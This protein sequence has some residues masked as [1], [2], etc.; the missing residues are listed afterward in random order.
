M[1]VRPR[2][3]NTR[4]TISG[5]NWHLLEDLAATRRLRTAARTASAQMTAATILQRSTTI[6]GATA[7]RNAVARSRAPPPC[8]DAPAHVSDSRKDDAGD[9]LYPEAAQTHPRAGAASMA[10]FSRAVSR[11]AFLP[12]ATEPRAHRVQKQRG[13]RPRRRGIPTESR[14][15]ARPEHRFHRACPRTRAPPPHPAASSP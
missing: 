5:P 2:Y 15:S 14:P 8:T 11:G 6:N 4:T 12:P 13:S 10:V 1:P 7:V 3:G 9:N